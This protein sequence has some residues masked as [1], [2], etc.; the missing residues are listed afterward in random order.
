MRAA[1]TRA[2]VFV[3]VLGTTESFHHQA[4]STDGSLVKMMGKTK[5]QLKARYPNAGKLSFV[6]TEDAP[7]WGVEG[8]VLR[9]SRGFAL[10][11]LTPRSLGVPAS[12]EII[13]EAEAKKAAAEAERQ[14]QIEEAQSLGNKLLGFGKFSISRK[15]GEEGMFGAVTATDVIGVI[16]AAAGV[17]L[18]GTKITFPSKAIDEVGDYSL[19]LTLDPEVSIDVV[20][21]LVEKTD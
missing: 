8:D 11:Y 9:V 3:L 13:A 20:L 19:K 16:S 15:I 4:P 21:S 2:L 6:L 14:A 7:P 12:P 5:K 17:D 10:N 18:D 1:M